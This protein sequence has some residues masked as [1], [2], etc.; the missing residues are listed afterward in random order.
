MEFSLGQ[1]FQKK[2]MSVLGLDIGSSSI[3]AVQLK[4]KGGKA[5]LETYG[6]LA[7]GPYGGVS[8]GQA[9]KLPLDKTSAALKDLVGEKEVNI[10]THN[11]GL[12]IP[13][14]ASLLTVIQVPPLKEKELA[15]MIP[16]EARKY[17]PVPISEVSLDWSVIPKLEVKS[18]EP[19]VADELSKNKAE[20]AKQESLD[21]LLAAI[22]NNILADY[23]KVV[24]DA[25]LSASFFEIELFS[26]MRSVMDDDVNSALIIDMGAASTKLYIVERGILRVSHILNIGAQ[27]ITAN[28]AR[29]NSISFQEAE[30]AKRTIGMN[31]T[32][33]SISI[34]DAATLVADRIFTEANRVVYGYESKYKRSL[35]KVILI[36]GGSSLKGWQ[37]LAAK[38]FKTE[39]IS[40]NPFAKVETPAFLKDILRET[41][42]E[43]AVSMGI[44]LRKLREL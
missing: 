15:A 23:S 20:P 11:C 36:G 39:V 6:E 31:P 40:G 3:K 5:V 28:A 8:V 21:I 7:L 44:A 43:F 32:G 29:M 17:I 26:S 4:K 22:H 41:G 12:S 37:E 25:G 27:D 38:N 42:P 9:T 30:V 14:H 34:S 18:Y 35:E 33:G 24:T 16:I 10:T 13:F 19:E 1:L 2:E